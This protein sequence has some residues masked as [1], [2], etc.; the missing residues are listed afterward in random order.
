MVLIRVFFLFSIQ[1]TYFHLASQMALLGFIYP[2]TLCRAG[3][4][5]NISRICTSKMDLNSGPHNRLSHC[6]RGHKGRFSYEPFWVP[7]KAEL[8]NEVGPDEFRLRANS[9]DDD[10][11]PLLVE[12]VKIA[13]C[14][15]GL[16]HV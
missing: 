11:P 3:I 1:C 13:P 8:V 12:R 9:R 14:S 6:N 10:H 4:R 16:H 2:S 15:N 5:T 7:E